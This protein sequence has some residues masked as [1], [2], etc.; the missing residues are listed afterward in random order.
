MNGQ[1]SVSK[2]HEGKDLVVRTFLCWWHCA[3]QTVMTEFHCM[4]I[5]ITSQL[6]HKHDTRLIASKV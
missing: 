4:G 2:R 3:D 5:F 1:P 6:D